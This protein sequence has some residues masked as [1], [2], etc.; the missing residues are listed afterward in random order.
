MSVYL[1]DIPLDVA[2]QRFESALREI[3]LWEILEAEEIPLDENALGRVLAEPVWA[4]TKLS[5]LPRL[6]NGWICRSRGGNTWRTTI[7]AN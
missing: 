1:K 2:L 7:H 3:G 4:K 5:A 6:G